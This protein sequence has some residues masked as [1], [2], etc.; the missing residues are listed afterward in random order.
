MSTRTPPQETAERGATAVITHRIREG[1]REAYDRWLE[2]IGP[3]CRSFPGHVDWQI[4][5]PVP[6]LT[7]T[8]TVILRFD[9]HEHLSGWM[10][11]TTRKELIDRVRPLLVTDDDFY[12][13]SG[14][15]FWFTPDGARAK[16]PVRWKQFLITWSA[17]FP[18]VSL[19]PLAVVPVLRLL[20]APDD[21]YFTTLV[22]TG[23]VVFLMVYAVMPRYT[24]LIHRWLF[25]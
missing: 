1:Q 15:D 20:G 19:V 17:I 3:I 4:I 12:L 8:Y 21:K 24:K 5:R 7:G 18:L 25:E 14:L 23:T 6:G 9:S 11:S 2:E 13:R 10:H 22:V 16:V